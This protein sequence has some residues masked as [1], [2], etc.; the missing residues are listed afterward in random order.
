MPKV[1]MQRNF[2]TVYLTY[3]YTDT[4]E[5]EIDHCNS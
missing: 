2:I 3:G 4:D 1:D 5:A